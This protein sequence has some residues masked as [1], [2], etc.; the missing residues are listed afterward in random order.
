MPNQR[1]A[2]KPNARRRHLA[3]VEP[4]SAFGDEG[5]PR[6]VDAIAE[7][8]AAL[9][10]NLT[11]MGLPRVTEGLTERIE[12]LVA[13]VPPLPPAEPGAGE[14]RNGDSR[15]NG[16]LQR[17]QP[18]GGDK[19]ELDPA[20]H[21]QTAI[22]LRERRVAWSRVAVVA[23]LILFSIAT[24]TATVVRMK[25]P[26]VSPQPD[27]IPL[28]SEPERSADAAQATTLL[29]D[30]PPQTEPR[31]TVVRSRIIQPPRHP[32]PFHRCA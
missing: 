8:E 27:Q 28:G 21:R 23:L 25:W 19:Y 26:T 15:I 20:H 3:I 14:D 9:L 1:P 10:S 22:V 6:E 11:R 16:D 17:F 2:L 29:A 31:L 13:D 24:A 5:S 18:R 7:L 32:R 4:R 12:Y 30:Q